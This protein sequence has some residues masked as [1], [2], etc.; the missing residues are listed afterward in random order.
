MIETES[1]TESESEEYDVLPLS[2][3]FKF[4]RPFD[5]NRNEFNTFIKNCNSAF[6]MA[7]PTQESKVIFIK[8]NRT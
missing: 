4:I 3:L 6:R 1:K 2:L 5:G 8:L 7:T